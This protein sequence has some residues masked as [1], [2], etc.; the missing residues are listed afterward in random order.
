MLKAV[1]QAGG[2]AIGFNANQY[3]LPYVTM[4]LA[5]THLSDLSPVL[6]MWR[7]GER[8]DVE[9]LVKQISP[10][11]DDTRCNFNWLAEKGHDLYDVISL[12][13]KLRK[14]VREKAGD[15]G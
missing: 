15:L 11:S 5:S 4:S 12:H 8:S 1:D 2:L 10:D 3:A 13:R 9:K 6:E 14:I 7:N